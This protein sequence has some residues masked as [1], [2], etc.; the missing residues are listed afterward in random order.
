LLRLAASF[1]AVHP[2]RRTPASTPPL[3]GESFDYSTP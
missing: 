1:E 3:P 2:N